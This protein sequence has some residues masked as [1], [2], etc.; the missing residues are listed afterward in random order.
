L[1]EH[2]SV[3]TR[4]NKKKI[5]PYPVFISEST[6]QLPVFNYFCVYELAN[7]TFT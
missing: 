6:E 1:K 2:S 5:G 4:K 7:I 3:F